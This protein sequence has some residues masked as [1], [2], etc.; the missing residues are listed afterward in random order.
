MFDVE[1]FIVD[2]SE[3]YDAGEVSRWICV[4]DSIKPE[5][6]GLYL[7]RGPNGGIY[8]VRYNGNNVWFSRDRKRV[9][10]IIKWHEIPKEGR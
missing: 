10:R 1:E 5:I 2:K 3:T 9:V 6:G 4:G 8:L 7:G